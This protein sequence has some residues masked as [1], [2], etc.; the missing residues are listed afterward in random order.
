MS[1]AYRPMNRD[2]AESVYRDYAGDWT[3]DYEMLRDLA[4]MTHWTEDE[5]KESWAE[6]RREWAVRKLMEVEA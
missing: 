3:R 6:A 5:L 1:G 2:D 4:C